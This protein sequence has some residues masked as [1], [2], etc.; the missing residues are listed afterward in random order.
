[1]EGLVFGGAYVRRE[2]CVSKPIGLACSG[3][4]IYHFCF[5]LLCIRGQ[6]PSTSPPGGAYIRRGDLTEGFFALPYWGAYIWRGL[7][8]EGLI[9]GIFRYFTILHIFSQG[10][11]N[12]II[13][14][15]KDFSFHRVFHRMF[16]IHKSFTWFS[17]ELHIGF[18]GLLPVVTMEATG[19][20]K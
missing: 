15:K 2:I 13:L 9:F 14:C 3:K 10:R 16:H 4:E 1:M 19:R 20:S 11:I 8:M 5:V 12:L 17:H 7:Y 6:I 18:T